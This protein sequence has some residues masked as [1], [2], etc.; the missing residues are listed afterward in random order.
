M[1]KLITG[2]H[3]PSKGH[4][5][6]DGKDYKKFTVKEIGEQVG[7]VMQMPNQMI[8]KDIIKDEVELA[9]RLR[10]IPEE[11]IVSRAAEAMNAC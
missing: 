8:V 10:D 3:R 9:L 5:F 6:V 4:I 1:A 11:E 7:Y 2:I